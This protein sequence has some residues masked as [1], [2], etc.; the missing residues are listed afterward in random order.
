MEKFIYIAVAAAVFGGIVGWFSRGRLLVTNVICVLLSFLMLA[1]LMI[2]SASSDG[3]TW[4]NW[5]SGL[6]YYVG[7]FLLFIFAPCCAAG[8]LVSIL[9]YCFR[10]G[11]ERN[12]H[13]D[14]HNAA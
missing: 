3:L 7:P 13:R 4:Q 12:I 11:K 1:A 8:V 6:I 2:S 9:S 10:C 5:S 14:E